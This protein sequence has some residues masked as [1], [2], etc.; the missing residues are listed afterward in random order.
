MQNESE[1][2]AVTDRHGVSPEDVS[3]T[4][5]EVEQPKIKTVAKSVED[6]DFCSHERLVCP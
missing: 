5:E 6:G 4:A 3:T 2:D 1:S